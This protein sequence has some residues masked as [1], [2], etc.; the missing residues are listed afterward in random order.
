MFKHLLLPIDGSDLSDKAAD[1]AIA[2]AA[3]TGARITSFMAIPEYPFQTFSDSAHET[4]GAYQARLE[5]AARRDLGKVQAAASAAGVSCAAET[6]INSS[7]FRAIVAKA[8]ELDCDL[9]VMASHGRSGLNSLLIGSETQKVLTHS[10][11][12][13]LVYR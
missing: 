3:S 5:A 8:T 6:A 4:R 7:P 12:P 1:A 11:I 9:I 10:T 2:F 13:V